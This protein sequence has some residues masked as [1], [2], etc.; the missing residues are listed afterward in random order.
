MFG[1]IPFKSLHLNEKKK[2][3]EKA[4]SLK[5]E[6]KKILAKKQNGGFSW[7]HTSAI[8]PCTP[9]K[10]HAVIKKPFC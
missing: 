7:K 8:L 2:I 3:I 9:K 1:F 10:P 6:S 4:F 5:K